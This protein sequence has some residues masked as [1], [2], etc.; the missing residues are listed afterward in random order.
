[1]VIQFIIDEKVREGFKKKSYGIFQKGGDAFQFGLRFHN[2]FFVFKR[3]LNHPEMQRFFF[4]PF[5]TPIGP[6]V[7]KRGK[8]HSSH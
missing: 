1:M 3:G 2:S 4:Q 6:I 5:V 7:Q 8:K